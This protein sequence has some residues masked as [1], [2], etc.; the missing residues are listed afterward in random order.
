MGLLSVFAQGGYLTLVQRS[1]ENL[2]S[3]VQM[4]YVNAYNTFPVFLVMCIVLGE[5]GSIMLSP[6]LKG[7]GKQAL[8]YGISILNRSHKLL[9]SSSST[10]S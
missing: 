7:E 8:I 2:S 6:N 9:R 3:T 4:I 10:Y 5:P 1:S